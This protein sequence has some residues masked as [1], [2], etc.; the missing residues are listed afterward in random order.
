MTMSDDAPWRVC[1]LTSFRG[2][3][4]YVEIA[5]GDSQLD[6][7][8]LNLP[9][10]RKARIETAIHYAEKAVWYESCES[11]GHAMERAR[12]IRALPPLFIRSLI[13]S[14]NPQWVDLGAMA[15]GFPFPYTIPETEAQR[16]LRLTQ[17]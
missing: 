9:E 11:E 10:S 15:L 4:Y 1:I 3:P 16:H 14:D 6:K 8:H 12:A 17:L 5:P 2:G 7:L 13:E